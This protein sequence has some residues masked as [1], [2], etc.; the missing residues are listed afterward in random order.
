MQF[1]ETEGAKIVF[2]KVGAG[3]PLLMITG[4]GGGADVYSRIA[5]VLGDSYEV[6]TY[7]RRCV[8][9][10]SGDV[11]AELD[12]AQQARDAV[13]VLRAAGHERAIVFGN[14]GGANIALQLAAGHAANVSLLVVHEPPFVRLLED[15]GKTVEFVRQVHDIFLREGAGAAM[16]VFA[17]SLVGFD[18]PSERP[19]DLGQDKDLPFFFRKEYLNLSLCD[20]ALDRITASN[21]PV[22]A[23]AG[24][25]SGDAYYVRTTEM[26]AQRLGCPFV[27]VPGNHLA[28]KLEPEPFA[29]ALRKV[30]ADH[31]PVRREP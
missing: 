17:G 5:G 23:L 25:K 22:V 26:V 8:A 14:S 9:R 6:I 21:V 31:P 3:T 10:S 28:M 11:D 1:V 24:E 2:E 20:I 19:R 4:A 16:R 15:G 7:D 18:I 27:K 29:Q 30:L 13:A 12:M